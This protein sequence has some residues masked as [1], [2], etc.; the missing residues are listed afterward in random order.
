MRRLVLV[1]FAFAL[2][3]QGA[4]AALSPD[5]RFGV[6]C[7]GA[8]DGPAGPAPEATSDDGAALPAEM[9]DADLHAPCDAS[10][11]PCDDDACHCHVPGL[12]ALLIPLPVLPAVEPD[13]IAAVAGVRQVAQHVPGRLLRPPHR[14][15][16]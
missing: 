12:V 6:C 9:H 7:A 16:A 1:L 13:A 3:C 14:A 8:V 11:L 10:P 4:L 2:L 5:C 15:T